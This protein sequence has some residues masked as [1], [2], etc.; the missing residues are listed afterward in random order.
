MFVDLEALVWGV[1]FDLNCTIRKNISNKKRT[2]PLRPQL[3]PR[4]TS[5]T[6]TTYN[7]QT[8][9]FKKKKKESKNGIYSNEIAPKKGTLMYDSPACLNHLHRKTK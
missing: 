1:T 2:N 9:P 4:I 8:P 3:T 5:R 7:N 6:R